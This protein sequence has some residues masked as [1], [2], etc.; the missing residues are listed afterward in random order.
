MKIKSLTNKD[1][2]DFIDA[3]A[4]SNI[5]K[6]EG[7]KLD[8]SFMVCKRSHNWVEF[9]TYGGYCVSFK[10]CNR[11]VKSLDTGLAPDI[12]VFMQV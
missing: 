6:P 2:S 5:S 1:V 7:N 9:E 8:S 10:L 11:G 3:H 12:Q 4:F